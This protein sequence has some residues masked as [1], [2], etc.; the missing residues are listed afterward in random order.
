LAK[1]LGTDTKQRQTNKRTCSF[2]PGMGWLQRCP[3][4]SIKTPIHCRKLLRV[5]SKT[6]ET[7][8]QHAWPSPLQHKSKTKT[9]TKQRQTDKRTC[10]FH[11]GMGWLQRCP[12]SSASDTSRPAQSRA[13]YFGHNAVTKTTKCRPVDCGSCR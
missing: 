13:T 4:S 9:E 6:T 7:I 12:F 11:P 5:T 1:P 10:S 2:Q 3:F 8:T